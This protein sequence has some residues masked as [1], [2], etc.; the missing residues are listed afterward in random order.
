MPLLLQKCSLLQWVTLLGA[1]ANHRLIHTFFKAQLAEVGGLARHM[2]TISASAKRPY[3]Q[4]P[5][6]M[7]YGYP[8]QCATGGHARNAVTDELFPLNEGALGGQGSCCRV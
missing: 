6:S 4:G 3:P 5:V 2:V 8:R 7:M 1:E